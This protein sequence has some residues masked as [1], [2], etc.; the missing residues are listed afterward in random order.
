MFGIGPM[1]RKG[2]TRVG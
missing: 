1:W 2:G